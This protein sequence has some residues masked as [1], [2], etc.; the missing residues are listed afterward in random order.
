MLLASPLLAR[1]G[2]PLALVADGHG[3]RLWTFGGE[4][5]N[6]LLGRVLETKLGPK[7]VID[8]QYV[9]FRE[10]AGLSDAAIRK[11]L[12]EL[13][14]E[15]CPNHDAALRFAE[16]CARCRISKFQPCLSD[17]LES[18]LLA[19]ALTNEDEARKALGAPE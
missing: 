5:A 3:L 16:S 12:A 15:Q 4:R 2:P 17:R 14:E 10:Q 1:P 8:N 13:H 7:I 6:N 18:E 19:E 11:A 9:A